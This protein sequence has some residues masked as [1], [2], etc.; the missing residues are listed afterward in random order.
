LARAGRRG[1]LAAF[2]GA[3]LA[4]LAFVWAEHAWPR[5]VPEAFGW[6]IY[7]GSYPW[8]LPWLATSAENPATAMAVVAAAFAFNVA[9]AAS[10]AGW[11][12]RRY[13]APRREGA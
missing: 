13:R 12:W 3:E 9:I 10:A 2:L 11:A 4:V 8:S 1:F 6:T 5:A 7:F